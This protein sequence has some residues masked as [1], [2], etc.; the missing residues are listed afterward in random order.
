MLQLDSQQIIIFDVGL[1]NPFPCS[2]VSAETI[3]V[4]CNLF[5]YTNQFEW[6]YQ[7]I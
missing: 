2:D 7:T 3:F 5:L 4:S 1:W 6:I